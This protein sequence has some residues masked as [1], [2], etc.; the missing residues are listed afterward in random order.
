LPH[1]TVTNVLHETVLKII[2]LLAQLTRN[3]LIN[4]LKNDKQ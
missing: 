2:L 1:A 3:T 4:T